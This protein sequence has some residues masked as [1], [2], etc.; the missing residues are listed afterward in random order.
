MWSLIAKLSANIV[1]ISRGL[2]SF[3]H[4]GTLVSDM[5]VSSK[6]YMEAW[7]LC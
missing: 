5:S 7:K 4:V 3:E 2:Q 1:R 6:A